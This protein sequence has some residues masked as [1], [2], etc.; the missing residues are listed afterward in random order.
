MSRELGRF[1]PG[2]LKTNRF[3][4][5]LRQEKSAAIVNLATTAEVK[6]SQETGRSCLGILLVNGYPIDRL[7]DSHENEEFPSTCVFVV[8]R[9]LNLKKCLKKR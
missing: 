3:L 1:N 9:L 8:E 4:I 7:L 6:N 2:I 5:F